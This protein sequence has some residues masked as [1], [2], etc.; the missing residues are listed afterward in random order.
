VG[1]DLGTGSVKVALVD[2]TGD[3][4]A[5]A[6]REYRLSSPHPGWAEIDPRVWLEATM[7]AAQD[8]GPSISSADAVGFCGQMHGVVLCDED[9]EPLRPAIT[10]ADTR[11]AREADEIRSD[12][13]EAV[14]CRLGSPAVPGYAATSLKW[15]ARHE[16]EVLAR[17]R[18]V[19]QPKDWLRARLGGAVVTEPS[20]ASGTLLVDVASGRWDDDAI[21]WLGI[22]RQLLPTI[23]GSTEPA[24]EVELAA[25]SLPCVVGAADTA[26][27]VVGMGVPVDGG[28]TAVGSG[29]Q[30]VSRV[31]DLGGG[32]AHGT[33]LFATAG[34]PGSGWYRIGAVQS[35]GVALVR[36]LA[37][38]AA[39][40]EE[41]HAALQ[42]GVRS[43]DPIFVPYLIGERTPF[44]DPML[45][46]AWLGLG[47]DTDR[48]AMLRSVLEGV[49]HAV[50]L[51]MQ[52]V[53]DAGAHLPDPLPLIGGGTLDPGFRQ[54]I[55]DIAQ[56]RI[57]PVHQPDV[58]VIGAAFLAMDI[59]SPSPP[60]LDSVIDPRPEVA[61]M[62]ADRRE[63]LVE[64]A[65]GSRS[66]DSST[67]EG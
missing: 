60:A 38:L 52:A 14:L 30:T 4:R 55:A 17:A 46:G 10:W 24:G 47:L 33:H 7:Q 57:A 67:L 45:R 65:R 6:S 41:A 20:D 11:A 36:A 63:R 53:E 9:L 43:S 34:D 2:E 26:A 13:G 8:L 15:L 19:L 48:P 56:R 39:T 66:L 22:D 37:V 27:A 64:Y 31:S 25:R 61:S 1:V 54:L 18:Y 44:L 3:V 42:S 59:V 32:L 28:F 12:L 49:A 23:V 58:S 51:G 50:V 35:A 62:F 29:S 40:T 21:T 5:A 16:P